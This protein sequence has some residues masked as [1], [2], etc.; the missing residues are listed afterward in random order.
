MKKHQPHTLLPF[1]VFASV[2]LVNCNNTTDKKATAH[3]KDTIATAAAQAMP[4]PPGHTDDGKPFFSIHYTVNG[5]VMLDFLSDKPLIFLGDNNMVV[6]LDSSHHLLKNGDMLN[7]Y[8]NAKKEGDYPVVASGAGRD[9]ATMILSFKQPDTYLPS[10]SPASGHVTITK[11]TDKICNGNYE[12]AATIGN[13]TMIL[14]G[15]FFN[16]SIN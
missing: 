13:N 4:E 14:K 2:L 1:L 7:I 10:F 8:I 9:S 6:Q 3:A 5:K 11:M 12:A 15:S 16:A